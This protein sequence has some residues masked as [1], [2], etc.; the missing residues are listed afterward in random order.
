M[1]IAWFSPLPP[2]HTDIAN[3]TQRLSRE[4]QTRFDTRFFKEQPEGFSEPTTGNSYPTDFGV[5]PHALVPE[6]NQVDLPIYHL[7]NNPVFF[8]HTWF[9]SQRK[10]GIVVLHDLKLHHFFEGIYRERLGDQAAYLKIMRRYYGNLGYE[11]GLAYWRQEISIDFM[12]EHFP[13]TRW[14]VNG[15]L[16]LVVHTEHALAVVRSLSDAP[17]IFAPLPYEPQASKSQ[18]TQTISENRSATFSPSHRAQLIIFGYLNVNRRVV[19]FLAALAEMS[20]RSYFDVQIYGTVF[21]RA[22]VEAAIAALGLGDRVTLHGYVSEQALEAGLRQAHL[23]VNLRYPSMGE[24]S[25]TQLR[26]W[27]HALPSLVTHTEG[28]TGLPTDTAFFVRISHE[29]ADIQQHLRAFLADPARFQAAGARGRET[30]LHNHSPSGYVDR[31]GA[32]CSHATNL[33]SRHNQLHLSDRVGTAV[34]S[35]LDAAPITAREEHYAAAIA[36]TV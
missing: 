6:L 27:D 3:Y 31:L 36:A 17:V 22:E 20:E 34:A 11:A 16:A 7:G 4:L 14:A 28:Y 19:Q 24:A 10:P 25:G 23:A 1:K 13:M 33:R 12:A 32:L 9:L 15:A 35:W 29:A 30:L 18:T 8:S 5:T 26:L 21:H 2:A